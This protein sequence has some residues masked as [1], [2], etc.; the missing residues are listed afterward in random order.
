MSNIA[1]IG[2]GA[3]GMMSAILIA[4]QGHAVTVFEQNERIGKKLYITGK[5][6]CNFTNA[7]T[8]DTFLASVIDNPR[9]LYSAYDTMDSDA[10]IEFFENHGMRTKVERGNRAFPASDKSSDVIDTL[11]DT[12]KR[13][14]VKVRLGCRVL[15]ILAEEGK[16]TGLVVKSSDEEAE[17]T[18]R[19]DRVIVATGGLSYPST[20]ATGDGLRFARE[21]GL[22]VTPTS[23]S[24][25][26][27]ECGERYCAEMQ[28]LSLRNVE[29][30]IKS[31]KKEVFREFGEMMFTHFGVTGPLIL[32][33]SAKIGQMIGKK[34]LRVYIDL[35]PAVSEEKLD[36]RLL[37]LFAENRNKDVQN[38]VS[39]LYPAKMLPVILALSGIEPGKKVHDITK[40]ERLAIIQMTKR[41]P[42][43][44]ERLRG[45][46]EAVITK[47]GVSVRE[48]DPGSMEAK[49]TAGLHF[50]GEVLD[51]DA[52][53]GGF[54]LQIAWCTAAQCAKAIG[55]NV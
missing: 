13:A 12:M 7:C 39:E 54:N 27:I 32:T 47:G 17:R 1:I 45:Y 29:L 21:L 15:S 36:D 34:E 52:L 43:T 26:P 16:V 41:F 24:L 23:P 2:A 30:H 22:R 31:G 5:G 10:V 14:G 33:A 9:F 19:F 4:E 25:V 35:K 51:V 8:R 50:I 40:G 53:T 49:K 44:F 28:G 46:N 6:R 38:V 42:L 55:P 37:R 11:R 18:L 48:I 3:A 20:G